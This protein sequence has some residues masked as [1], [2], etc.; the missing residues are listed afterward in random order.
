MNQS[1]QWDR[2]WQGQ[3]RLV[4]AKKSDST[5]LT[6]AYHHAPFKIQ[7]SFYPEGKSICHN[8]ILH[9]AGGMVGGDRLSTDI[10]LHPHSQVLTTTATANRIYRSNGPLSAHHVHI[11]MDEGATLEYLPQETI[12]FNGANYQQT[13][14][15]ELGTGSTFI[16]WE[17]YRFGRT[18]RG[19]KFIQGEMR[20]QT[21]LW[22]DK[23]PLWI[24]RQYVPGN[25]DIFHSAHGLSGCPVVGT[26]VF[27]GMPVD[28]DL[29]SQARSLI[30]SPPSSGVTRLEQGLLCRFR[31]HSTSEVKQWF[32]N[33][34]KILRSNYLS[35]DIIKTQAMPRVW[36]L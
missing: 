12:I 14:R 32:M 29:V 23:V 33:V 18:A 1:F 2:G 7:R 15:V 25:E 31:G 10:H 24:D 6:H 9:T 3:L 34:W 5:Y 26:L 27:V 4:Y 36:Q 21:E 17:I 16:G 22:Q 19:E 35:Y 30:T 28:S 8:I 11:K 13:L 20:S